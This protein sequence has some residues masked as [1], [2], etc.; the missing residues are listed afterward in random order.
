MS[1]LFH[2]DAEDDIDGDLTSSIITGG[3]PLDT[4][5]P[6]LQIITYD[7]TDSGGNSV[8]KKRFIQ[9]VEDADNCAGIDNVPPV[10]DV[11]GKQLKQFNVVCEKRK[12]TD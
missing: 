7:V 1:R 8:Q 2:N 9:V 3:L 5:E 11:I 4:S 12:S 6:G 10:I